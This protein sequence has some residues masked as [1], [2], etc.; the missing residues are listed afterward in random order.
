[1]KQF[2]Y[3]E[4]RR[5]NRNRNEKISR[6]EMYTMVEVSPP[7]NAKLFKLSAECEKF[8]KISG[9]CDEIYK[10]GSECSEK[11]Q[12]NFAAEFNR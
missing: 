4:D 1:M 10:S 11:I 9:E 12:R 2:K 6:I 5:H 7:F 3:S 8:C